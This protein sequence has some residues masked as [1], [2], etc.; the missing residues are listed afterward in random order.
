MADQQRSLSKMPSTSRLTKSAQTY[1]KWIALELG[2]IALTMGEDIGEKRLALMVAAL[3][4]IEPEPLRKALE[5]APKEL[6]FFPRP[7][8]ILGIVQREAYIAEIEAEARRV[9][10]AEEESW[11]KMGPWNWIGEKLNNIARLTGGQ[12]TRDTINAT[13]D[14]LLAINVG[15]YR[16]LRAFI[17]VRRE[18]KHFPK[19][20]EVIERLP[21]KCPRVYEEDEAVVQ[22]PRPQGLRLISDDSRE[23]DVY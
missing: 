17:R 20:V 4:E 10:A 13:R 12:V 6:K 7:A 8:E 15:G 9:D 14:E 18:C 11:N 2:K 3:L 23:P 16:L 1:A 22:T 21:P 5:L 19:P